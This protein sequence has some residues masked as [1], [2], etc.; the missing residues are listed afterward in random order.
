[1]EKLV[2]ISVTATTL[3]LRSTLDAEA[4]PVVYTRHDD[5]WV[6]RW[7]GPDGEFVDITP[8]AESLR[9]VINSAT[10]LAVGNG[11]PDGEDLVIGTGEDAIRLTRPQADCVQVKGSEKYCRFLEVK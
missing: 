9:V 3:K 6:G 1:L 10:K 4:V 11:R 5:P 2:I 7:S 8:A